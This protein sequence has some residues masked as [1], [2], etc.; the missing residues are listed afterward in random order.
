MRRN[1]MPL[2]IFLCAAMLWAGGS[3]VWAGQV[4]TSELRQ[5]AR[6]AVA[7][8]AKLKTQPARNTLAVLYFK[9]RTQ[10]SE[11]DPLQKGFAIMLIT[12]L[13]KL[14]RVQVV[15]RV[16]IQALVEELGLGVT[17]LVDR[18][19]AP[20]VGRL[21]GAYYLVGGGFFPR[22]F[23]IFR[24]ASY[25]AETESRK[26]LG[27][28]AAEAA[29]EELF[30]L[31]KEIIFQIIRLLDLPMTSEEEEAVRKPFSTSVQ[32][33]MDF[34]RGI[35]QADRGRYEEAA[36]LYRKALREDPQLRAAEEALTELKQLGLVDQARRRRFLWGLRSGVSLTDQLEPTE[37]LKR[38]P[39][40]GTLKDQRS[41]GQLPA[42]PNELPP[43]PPSVGK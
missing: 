32:A 4:V 34:F 14:S 23:P 41:P 42:P 13:A 33:A 43:S 15:E 1:L 8:E 19:T 21:L 37:V 25:V 26:I 36:R 20:R 30:D 12:D 6:E 24:C 40:A 10:R 38:V 17:G 9:N 2:G 31:E 18:D 5:W 11:L 29:L 35:D 39:S 27:E 3:R 22:D 7:R 28:P 16:K